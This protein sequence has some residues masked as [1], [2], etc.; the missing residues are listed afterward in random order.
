MYREDP[1][2]KYLLKHKQSN[3]NE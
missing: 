2:D 3:I 1:R